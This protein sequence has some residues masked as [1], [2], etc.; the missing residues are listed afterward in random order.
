MK[1]EI[2]KKITERQFTLDPQDVGGH[3][4]WN[5]FR[6]FIKAIPEPVAEEY[7]K[8]MFTD[9]EITETAFNYG[10]GIDINSDKIKSAEHIAYCSGLRKGS[11]M[12][13]LKSAQKHSY[14]S[15]PIVIPKSV[16]H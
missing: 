11:E 4:W 16:D 15:R 5:K 12:M 1:D 14:F 2:L 13:W 6:E 7:S 3:V 9:D 8:V 10:F